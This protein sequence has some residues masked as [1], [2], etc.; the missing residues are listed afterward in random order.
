[1][2][3]RRS[4]PGGLAACG[5][6][7]DGHPGIRHQGAHLPIRSAIFTLELVN[8]C[9]G[10][11]FITMLI[12]KMGVQAIV[13]R[14]SV[15]ITLLFAALV[16]HAPAAAQ[17]SADEAEFESPRCVSTR[18]IR[19]IRILDDRNVLIYL[20]RNRIYHNVL[21][22]DC[23][24]LK[25]VGSFSYTSNDGLLCEGD[26]IGSLGGA[27][28]NVRPMASCWLGAHKRVSNEEAN[29]LRAAVRR[30]PVIKVKPVAPPEPSEIGT[31]EPSESENPEADAQSDP[32][33]LLQP[34]ARP[35]NNNPVTPVS[36]M[37]PTND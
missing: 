33:P 23:R 14:Y 30:G 24:G 34:L 28:D 18:F 27:W 5:H 1:M 10:L 3:L 4:N 2:W 21:R 9:S 8:T 13:N 16:W 19:R 29:E 25:R 11:Y 15:Q 32:G 35:G 20:S 22:Y 6:H 31:E 26:G 37:T 17:G 36:P 7:G 12:G